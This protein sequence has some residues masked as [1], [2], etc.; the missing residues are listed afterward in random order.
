VKVLGGPNDR[1][2][3]INDQ[4]R[5]QQGPA[6]GQNSISVDHEGLVFVEVKW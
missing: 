1:P 2:A 5:E 6:R 4:T 3:L